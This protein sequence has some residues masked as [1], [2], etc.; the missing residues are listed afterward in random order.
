[1]IYLASPYTHKDEMMRQTRYRAALRAVAYLLG[2]SKHVFS[3]IVHCH[4]IALA[5]TLPGEFFFWQSYNEDMIARCDSLLVL[6][7]PGWEHSYGVMKEIE[8]AKSIGKPV[9]Y[10]NEDVIWPA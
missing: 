9:D 1:M 3:P 4:M 5:Y 10:L 7:L 8:F 6:Q 2:E